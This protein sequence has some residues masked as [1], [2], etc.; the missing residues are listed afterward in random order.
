MLDEVFA[1]LDSL[2]LGQSVADVGAGFGHSTRYLLSRGLRVCAVDVDP[3]TISWLRSAFK[4]FVEVG[5]LRLVHAPAEEIPLRDGECDSA[6]SIMALHHFKDV[7]RALKEMARVAKK[8]VVIYDWAPSTG[9]VTNPHSPR[10]LKAKME[11]AV[12]IAKR[13]GFEVTYAEAWYK[14]AKRKT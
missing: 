5:M 13:L 14:L 11:E 4:D 7:E 3:S 6:V 8:Q 10:E 1:D 12:R 2:D 9:G